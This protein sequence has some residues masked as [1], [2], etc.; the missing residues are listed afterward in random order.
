MTHDIAGSLGMLRKAAADGR[1][2][3]FE[4]DPATAADVLARETEIRPYFDT[5]FWSAPPSYR[6]LLAETNTLFCARGDDAFRV[7][8]AA[9]MAEVNLNLVH[10]PEGVSRDGARMLSTNHLVGFAAGRGEGVWCFDVSNP[11]LAGEYPVYYHHQDEPRA[12]YLEDALSEDPADDTPDLPSFGAWLEVMARAFTAAHPPEWLDALG[13][14]R[15][16]SLARRGVL[17]VDS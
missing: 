3:L 14:P 7:L 6:A 2:E 12:R 8:D 10:M 17:R 15:L 1:I 5:I 9:D 4:S 13:A 11:D 16:V